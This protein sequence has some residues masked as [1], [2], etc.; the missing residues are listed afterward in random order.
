M[1]NVRE[2][3]LDQDDINLV[4]DLLMSSNT[5]ILVK[6]NF[7]EDDKKDNILKTLRTKG[8][9]FSAENILVCTDDDRIVGVL[10]AFVPSKIDQK[11]HD[12]HTDKSKRKDM[13]K[14]YTSWRTFVLPIDHADK[15]LYINVFGCKEDNKHAVAK[16]FIEEVD[17]IGKKKRYYRVYTDVW[18][19]ETI[20][21]DFLKEV[22]FKP[23][24]LVDDD[25]RKAHLSEWKSYSRAR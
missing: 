11:S 16:A 18:N 19:E 6:G 9:E 25:A 1:F 13:R 17:R 3:S 20:T 8:L 14:I 10:Q 21:I 4:V 22:G 23:T 2:L 15:S 7:S 5:I 12:I 24:R